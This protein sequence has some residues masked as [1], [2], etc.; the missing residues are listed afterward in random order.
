MPQRKVVEVSG[1][2]SGSR[3][4]FGF[5]ARKAKAR[6]SDTSIYM[7]PTR[8]RGWEFLETAGTGM[9]ARMNM[10]RHCKGGVLALFLSFSVILLL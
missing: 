3:K 5:D 2:R 6:P 7:M 8:R 10:D 1:N 9:G 4:G